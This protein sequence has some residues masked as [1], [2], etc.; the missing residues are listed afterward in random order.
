MRKDAKRATKLGLIIENAIEIKDDQSETDDK[1]VFY[2]NKKSSSLPPTA[3]I[4]HANR[5]SDGVKKSITSTVEDYVFTAETTLDT[6]SSEP[7]VMNGSTPLPSRGY[8][9]HREFITN[10]RDKIFGN[11]ETGSIQKA[12]AKESGIETQPDQT[13]DVRRLPSYITLTRASELNDIAITSPVRTSV[14][15]PHSELLQESKTK[16][17]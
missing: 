7:N 13:L 15:V 12:S 2:M 4:D 9:P 5:G 17:E 1:Q 6:I 8:V 10:D 16:P 11:T 3:N 14:Y